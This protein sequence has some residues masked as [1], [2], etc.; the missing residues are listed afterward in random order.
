MEYTSV[1]FKT[2][3][4]FIFPL[5]YRFGVNGWILVK[6]CLFESQVAGKQRADLEPVNRLAYFLSKLHL[7]THF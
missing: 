1:N 3:L 6:E 4:Y 2:N 7:C 5:Y